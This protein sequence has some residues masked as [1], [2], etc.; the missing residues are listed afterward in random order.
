VHIVAD[1]RLASLVYQPEERAQS[2]LALPFFHGRVRPH[3]LKLGGGLPAHRVRSHQRDW[4]GGTASDSGVLPV[5]VGCNPQAFCNRNPRSAIAF[6]GTLWETS[7]R[8]SL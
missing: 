7:S 1:P 5:A 6:V 8:I 4:A 3:I 2:P